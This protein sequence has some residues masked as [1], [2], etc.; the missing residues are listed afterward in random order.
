V[1]DPLALSV[2]EELV[3]RIAH[4]AA[5]LVLEQL[6]AA[7]GSASPWL[8]LREAANYLRVSERQLQRL[9][10][11]GKLRSTTIGRRRLLHRDDLDEMATG[12]DVA[13]TT[14]S[15]RQGE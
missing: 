15:R 10:S 9:V 2:P 4:R 13:P 6:G 7:N 8:S 12:E 3:E 1:S 14:P 11:R 5:E